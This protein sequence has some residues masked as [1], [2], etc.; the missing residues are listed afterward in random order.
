M[1]KWLANQPWL[2]WSQWKRN[3]PSPASLTARALSRK[4][5][6][7]KHVE[8]KRVQQKSILFFAGAL[9]IAAC[10]R[11]ALPSGDGFFIAPTLVGGSTPIILETFTALPASPTPP[12]DNHL[13]FLRDISVPDGTRFAPGA[14]IEKS[15]E[16]RNDGTCP[17][18]RGYFVQLEDGPAMGAIDRQAL[19]EAQPGEVVVLTIQ[20]TAPAASG[21]HRS[22]WRA[23]DFGGNPFGV[24]FFI[25]IVVE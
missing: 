20:F 18:S 12:C 4:Q 14:P 19:P 24:L 23:H 5:E 8:F 13:V 17:W 3:N 1:Q 11:S 6:R 15:W 9:L 2:N 22:S 10:T 7:A 21:I 16:V 25:D